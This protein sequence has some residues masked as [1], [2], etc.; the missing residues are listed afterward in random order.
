[1]RKSNSFSTSVNTSSVDSECLLN[2]ECLLIVKSEYLL[3]LGIVMKKKLSSVSAS[4][5]KVIAYLHT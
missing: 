2:C 4:F 1:M 5:K 3:N